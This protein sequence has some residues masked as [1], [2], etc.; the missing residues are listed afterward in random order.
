MAREHDQ[1]APG[2]GEV[3]TEIFDPKH[4]YAAY[5]YDYPQ[6]REEDISQLIEMAQAKQYP[7]RYW[8]LSDATLVEDA[9]DS[10]IVCVHHQET[11]EDAGMDLYEALGEKGVKWD[12][13][14]AAAMHEYLFLGRVI[15]EDTELKYPDERPLFPEVIPSFL[16]VSRHTGTAATMLVLSDQRMSTIPAEARLH[17]QTSLEN[18]AHVFLLLLAHSSEFENE[19]YPLNETFQ[20]V[21]TRMKELTVFFERVIGYEPPELPF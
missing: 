13:L 10:L 11:G 18:M 1:P 6:D 19:G 15:D 7:I 12:M 2:E 14:E 17:M 21:N 8:W 16:H 9:P 20:L 5:V 4:F 3:I